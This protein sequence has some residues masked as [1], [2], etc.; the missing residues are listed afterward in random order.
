M[1]SNRMKCSTCQGAMCNLRPLR[2]RYRGFMLISVG[3]VHYNVIVA[4][5]KKPYNLGRKVGLFNTLLI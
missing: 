1:G 2:H 3:V 4:P 5:T